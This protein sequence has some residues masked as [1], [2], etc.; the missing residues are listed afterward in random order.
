MSFLDWK[1]GDK[2]VC[3]KSD[4]GWIEVSGHSVPTRVP[5]LREILT[6]QEITFVPEKDDV[7]LVFREIDKRQ[8][9]GPLAADI[10]WAARCFRPLT[11][12]KSDISVF[13]AMLHDKRQ[14]VRA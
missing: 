14:K 4:F 6:I 9:D 3:V 11:T 1:V 7:F 8:T 12:A 2:V 13:T 5:M 10:T